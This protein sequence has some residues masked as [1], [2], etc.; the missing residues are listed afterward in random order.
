[1]PEEG[2]VPIPEYLKESVPSAE[3]YKQGERRAYQIAETAW[4]LRIPKDSLHNATVRRYVGVLH[5]LE[6]ARE[7]LEWPAG[8]EEAAPEGSALKIGRTR[9]GCCT[10]PHICF[11]QTG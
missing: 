9:S 4:R 10:W 5:D 7:R 1:M 11:L 3:G 8:M 6:A 2:E